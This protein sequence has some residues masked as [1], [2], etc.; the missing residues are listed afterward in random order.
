MPKARI[1]IIALDQ[2]YNPTEVDCITAVL[3]WVRDRSGR[4]REYAEKEAAMEAAETFGTLGFVLLDEPEPGDREAEARAADA[5][6]QEHDEAVAGILGDLIDDAEAE[7]ALMLSGRFPNDRDEIAAIGPISKGRMVV[8]ADDGL[9][10]TVDAGTPA[11][12]SMLMIPRGIAPWMA[13]AIIDA[14]DAGH[15]RGFG[16]GQ[17]DMVSAI[18]RHAVQLS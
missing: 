8:P 5:I 11:A 12:R 9:H 14:W 3:F 15:R 18:T 2:H 7:T 4:T 17:A 16:D 1:E 13:R 10:V 6:R